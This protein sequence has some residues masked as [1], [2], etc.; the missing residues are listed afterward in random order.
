MKTAVPKTPER[1]GK[2]HGKVRGHG[3]R[4]A[5]E[6]SATGEVK[7]QQRDHLIKNFTPMGENNSA[8]TLNQSERRWGLGIKPSR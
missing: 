6:E 4:P 5:P 8:K 1:E 7:N 2:G 3:Y